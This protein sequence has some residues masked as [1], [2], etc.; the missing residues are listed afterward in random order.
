MIADLDD[1]Q[2]GELSIALSSL[3]R[4]LKEVNK[5]HEAIG[6]P[7]KHTKVLNRTDRRAVIHRLGEDRPQRSRTRRRQHR[8]DVQKGKFR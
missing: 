2:R 6:G 3:R 8:I 1:K 5:L 4:K 7:P